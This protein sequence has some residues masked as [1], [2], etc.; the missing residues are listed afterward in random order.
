MALTSAGLP[1][2]SPA[3]VKAW[4]FLIKNQKPNG[5]WDVTSRAYQA[6][7]FSSYMGTAWATLGLVRTLPESSETAVNTALPMRNGVISE[8]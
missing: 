6:P 1:T 5:S 3:I 7:E 8:N 4:G 2:E